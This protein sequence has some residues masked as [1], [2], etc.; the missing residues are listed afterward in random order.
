MCQDVTPNTAEGKSMMYAITWNESGDKM[1]QI[2]IE[3][4]RLL[5]ELRSN[6]I[7]EVIAN[8][9]AYEG[10]SIWVADADSGVICGSTDDSMI[11]STLE[12][13]GISQTVTESD[14]TISDVV[15]IG[16][17]RN[18]YN[19]KKAGEYIVVVAN[20]ISSSIKNVFAAMVIELVYLIVAGAIIIYVTH[21]IDKQKQKEKELLIKSNVDELTGLYNRRAY[22]DDIAAHND[23]ATEDNFVFVSLDVNGLKKVNDSLG[24]VAGDELL[25]GAAN[26]MKQC[27]GPYGKIY[28]TGG[29]EFAAIIY[30]NENQL[31]SIKR[32]FEVVTSKWAGCLVD[33][34]S[35]SCGYVTKYEVDT[36][37]VHEIANIADRRM[38]EEKSAF[39]SKCCH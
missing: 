14:T 29:D 36:S 21:N 38:Y 30:V 23:A 6:E 28:R 3:P 37:S 9:P 10:I 24:H 27:F 39:Y 31:Q 33:G 26:C 12:E 11:G 4:L 20:S 19:L 5:E 18:Y 8:M 13:T 16:K 35:V 17:Y 2:G 34:L 15:K 32:N 7:S 22:E 25:V 1:I